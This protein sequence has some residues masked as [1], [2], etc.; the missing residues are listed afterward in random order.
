VADQGVA[1][2]DDDGDGQLAA[3][4]FSAWLAQI[5]AALRGERE[6]DV[7]CGGCTACCTAAQFVHIAPDETDA[8]AH[9]PAQLL[10]PAPMLPRGHVVLGYDERGHCP[11]LVD[12]RCSIYAHRPQACRTY[13]CRV[14]PAAGV[15]ADSGDDRKALIATRAR[16]WRF[17]VTSAADAV[18]RDAVLA[19]AT[20][21]RDR[22]DVL[23]GSGALR[24][25]TGLAVLAISAHAAFVGH[26]P[27]GHE[28]LIAEP[29]ADAVR[30]E[31]RRQ[32][33]AGW[34]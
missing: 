7:P 15:E 19:A 3:G 31:L 32:A 1:D 6:S 4:E 2:P 34:V 12:D 13:D 26:D 29:E 28:L 30:I 16:R 14:F 8:L 11:M 27:G 17:D 23:G 9:I 33:A 25:P 20:F 21:I 24:N 18:R 5:Q 10:F 22:P